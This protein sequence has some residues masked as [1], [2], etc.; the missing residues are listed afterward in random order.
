[1]QTLHYPP[2]PP[3]GPPMYP[4][5]AGYSP[6]PPGPM[7]DPRLPPL[8]LS[9]VVGPSNKRLAPPQPLPGESPAKKK[10]SKW[11]A[12][13]DAAIVELRGSGMKWEDVSRHLAGRS[14]I[15]CR[16]RFQNYLERRA[17]WDEEKKNKLA[18]L[19]ERFK[20]DMW[21]KIAKEMQLP[22]RA[23]EA[24]HWQIG[25]VEMAQRANVP[26]FHLAGQAAI[27]GGQPGAVGETTIGTASPSSATIPGLT[28]PYSHTHNHSLPQLPQ[29]Y[30]HPISPEQ[31]RL[32]RNSN[33]STPS[34]AEAL[35]RRADSARSVPTPS[36]LTR[37]LLPPL[38]DLTGTPAQTR[39]TLPP[40]VTSP[41][42][43]R[44]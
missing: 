22:W 21:E 41:E 33:G 34:A 1:M 27:S 23:A 39:Y 35:R 6:Y 19:Y 14:A 8:S 43:G 24:M 4:P 38:G 29:S 37:T 42:T 11:S 17:E 40:V 18:R 5:I 36:S 3:A 2:Y 26:M 31:A 32:R 16:L 10:Q 25:E 28:G 12:D 44:R 15:S 13:E 7:P 9:H 20:K 30:P